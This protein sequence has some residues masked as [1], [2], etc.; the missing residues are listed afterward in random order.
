[1]KTE[2]L[3]AVFRVVLHVESD[4]WVNLNWSLFCSNMLNF[5]QVK[6]IYEAHLKTTKADQ[7]ALQ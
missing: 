2:R 5:S 4:P 7:S 1:M 6:S 3:A